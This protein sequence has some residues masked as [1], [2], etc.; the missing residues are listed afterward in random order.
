MIISVNEGLF[1]IFPF[2]QIGIIACEIN[3]TRYGD[4]QLEEVLDDTKVHFSF[5]RPEDHPN[6]KVWRDAFRKLAIPATE[7]YSSVERLLKQALKG[8]PFPRDNPLMDLYHAVSLKHLVPIGCH[9][10][11]MIEGDICLCFAE[12]TESFIPLNLGESELVEKGEV[13]YRDDKEALSRRW[14]WMQSQKSKV[15]S[16]TTHALISFDIMEGLPEW[17]CKTVMTDLEESILQNE[18]GKILHKSILTKEHMSTE[19]SY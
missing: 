10:L 18:Y 4:D 6:I 3:N 12:G 2:L 14:V 16:E 19:F 1:K 17:L 13:I 8:G 9:A 5:E 7:Y 15:E 11:Q